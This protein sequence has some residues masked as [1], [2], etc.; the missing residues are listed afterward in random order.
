MMARRIPVCSFH[1]TRLPRGAHR[2]EQ[3]RSAVAQSLQQFAEHP[4]LAGGRELAVKFLIELEQLI[5]MPGGNGEHD[6]A[7]GLAA[8]L[9][10]Q[11]RLGPQHRVLVRADIKL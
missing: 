10:L 6:T 11:E 8:L 1:E 7:C 9:A 4:V 5:E 3:H 2:R